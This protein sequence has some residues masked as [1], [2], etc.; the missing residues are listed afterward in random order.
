M[1]AAPDR[2][3]ARHG[4]DEA[5]EVV[6]LDD[7]RGL[8]VRARKSFATG[9][10]MHRFAGMVSDRICQHSLQVDA[11]R[12]VSGTRYIGYLSHGCDP[13]ATLHMANFTLVARRE[14]APGDIVTIDYTET[15]DKLYRQFSCSC[16]ATNCRGWIV[17][18]VEQPN[19]E[20]KAWL[21]RRH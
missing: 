6:R 4:D 21:S 9:D 20:G 8:G 10:V 7:H 12:H 15:E 5:L 18:R 1:T 3:T 14:I 11:D 17:G 19:D 13:N 2:A 16:G